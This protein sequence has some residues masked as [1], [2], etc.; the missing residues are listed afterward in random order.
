MLE[1][2]E[3]VRHYAWHRTHCVFIVSSYVPSLQIH[4]P[5]DIF[6]V[7]VSSHV[8]HIFAVD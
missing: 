8:R 3:H 5:E 6:L 7:R 1:D 4:D 2:P